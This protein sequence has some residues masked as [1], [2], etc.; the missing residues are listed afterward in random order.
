MNPDSITYPRILDEVYSTHYE[1]VFRV[2]DLYAE[3]Y[4]LPTISFRLDTDNRG[5]FDYTTTI[6]SFV[7]LVLYTSTKKVFLRISADTSSEEYY[8]LATH[9]LPESSVE[10]TVYSLAQSALPDVKIAGV[11][12]FAI[13]EHTFHFSHGVASEKHSM[14]GIAYIAR[15]LDSVEFESKR[16]IPDGSF[17][18]L[19]EAK[20]FLAQKKVPKYSNH[21]VLEA[22]L[23]R[24]D[25][26]FEL[27]IRP[28]DKEISHNQQAASRYRF[29]DIFVKP[30]FAVL[31]KSHSFENA[32]FD[33]IGK[34][35]RFLDV[36]CGDSDLVLQVS[37]KGADLCVGNDVSWSQ[38]ALLLDRFKSRGR[39]NILFTNHNIVFLPYKERFFDVALCKNTL[40]HL[41]SPNEFRLAVENLV[42]VA[43]KVVIVE[44]ENPESGLFPRVVNRYYSGFLLDA[45]EY[46]FTERQFRGSLE[47]TLDRCGHYYM[48]I[49]K[50][51]SLIGN[52][53]I[54]EISHIEK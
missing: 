4:G 29:H 50:H 52:Y 3:L 19:G 53:M 13:L 46:F 28:P 9:V 35:V 1:H 45:G 15:I 24:L 21:D 36:S 5:Y 32:L 23:N 8:L 39:S 54:A 30:L 42:R 34:P 7:V 40:H 44:I 25:T 22:A 26:F 6:S 27:R 51:R 38:I 49:T 48:S 31:K 17:F 2:I 16:V 14:P 11:E 18:P 47:Q 12:P 33:A 10:D 43:K 37:E 41:G 20:N